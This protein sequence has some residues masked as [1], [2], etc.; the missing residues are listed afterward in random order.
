[1]LDALVVL[2]CRIAPGDALTDAASRRVARASQAFAEGVAPRIIVSGGRRW[3]AR[4]E[5]EVFAEALGGLGVPPSALVLELLSF[6]TAENARYT[7]A[8]AREL[9]YR[10]LGVVTCDF[11]LRRALAAFEA[12]GLPAQ[13]FAARTPPSPL[14][15]RI[16]RVGRE[17]VSSFVDRLA[18]WGAAPP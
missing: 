13:G 1:M 2:G 17:R 3:T 14:L 12:A 4:A 10:R 9:G 5:A 7:V 11:H 18:T 16:A 6:S 8:L 15:D